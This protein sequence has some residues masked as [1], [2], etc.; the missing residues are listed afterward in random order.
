MPAF[1]KH[2]INMILIDAVAQI[3]ECLPAEMQTAPVKPASAAA[4]NRRDGCSVADWEHRALF[5]STQVLVLE[6]TQMGDA[7]CLCPALGVCP[8]CLPALGE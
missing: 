7:G 3:P 1:S 4:A 8:L 2:F 5:G 6:H